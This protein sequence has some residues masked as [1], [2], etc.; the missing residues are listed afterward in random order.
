MAEI[1]VDRKDENRNPIW[2]WILGALVLI[3]LIWGVSELLD[4][5]DDDDRMATRTETT[6]RGLAYEN[7]EERVRNNAVTGY[8]AQG[9]VSDYLLFVDR[10]DDDADLDRTN[11]SDRPADGTAGTAATTEMGLEHEYTSEG[12]R[13]LSAALTALAASS[14]DAD[15]QQKRTAFQQNADKIQQD[16]MSLQHANTIRT[17]FTQAADLMATIKDRSYPDS[18]ADVDEV[19][20]AAEAIDVNEQTLEQ[21]D[22]VREFFRKSG[23]AIQAMDE[24]RVRNTNT[25]NQSMQQNN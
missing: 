7:E 19:R 12:I 25:N 4:R 15:I 5:D 22:E 24:Q 20:E 9:P 14:T 23:E 1:R 2:P 13:K 18:D 3:G 10:N 17:T 16:P 6:D 8:E 21:K 11:V